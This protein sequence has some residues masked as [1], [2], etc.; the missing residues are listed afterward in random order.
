MLQ[1]F[2]RDGPHRNAPG[3]AVGVG[4]TICFMVDEAIALWR[5]LESRGLPARRPFVGNGMWVT[6]LT[7]PDGYHLLFESPADAPEESVFGEDR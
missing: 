3:T 7:D 4:V 5:E 2:W 6:E 1:E